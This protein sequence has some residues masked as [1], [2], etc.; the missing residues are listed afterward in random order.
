LRGDVVGVRFF[1][2]GG[3][4]LSKTGA[5]QL[6][7]DETQTAGFRMIDLKSN[8]DAF[9]SALDRPGAKRQINPTRARR[10]TALLKGFLCIGA[11]SIGLGTPCKKQE[12]KS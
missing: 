2:T 4:P 6:Q 10:A 3:F 9:F 5:I 11:S 1:E 8:R 12:I 7:S